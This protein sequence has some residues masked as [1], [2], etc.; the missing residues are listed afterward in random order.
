[1]FQVIVDKFP[2]QDTKPQAIKAMRCIDK[3][4]S[5]KEVLELYEHLAGH[6]PCAVVAGVKSSVAEHLVSKLADGQIEAH[7]ESCD[8]RTPMMFR[9]GV[10][11]RYEWADGLFRSL[12]ELPDST[13]GVSTQSTGKSKAIAGTEK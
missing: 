1:M 13:Y 7:V 5:L 6:T 12:K 11:T 8:L 4:L 9:A 2:A 3:A 10:N